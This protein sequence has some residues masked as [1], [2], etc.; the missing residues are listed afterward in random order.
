MNKRVFKFIGI[1]EKVSKTGTGN[2]PFKPS[3]PPSLMKEPTVA[4][5]KF[6]LITIPATV[7]IAINASGN[8]FVAFIFG[9][10]HI[11]S[12]VSPTRPIIIYKFSP[13]SHT[14]SPPIVVLNIPSWDKKI[15]IANPLTNPI[16][17]G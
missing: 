1:F 12:M 9:K 17:T 2:P 14:F 16:I 13:S 4:T 8:F 3:P 5:S 10:P 15:T 7:I 6:V 11:I